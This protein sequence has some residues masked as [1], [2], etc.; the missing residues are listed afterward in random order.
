MLEALGMI[1]TTGLIP[2]VEAADVMCK[3]AEVTCVGLYKVGRGLVSVIVSGNVGAVNAAV[4][5]GTH[6]VQALGTVQAVHVIARP[7]ESLRG[8]VESKRKRMV[9]KQAARKR[10]GKKESQA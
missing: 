1:E 9:N 7:D 2:A 6:A 4:E 5:A 3:A 10:A 8:F